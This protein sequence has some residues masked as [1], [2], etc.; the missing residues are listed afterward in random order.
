LSAIVCGKISAC[1]LRSSGTRTTPRDSASQVKAQY[2]AVDE[3]FTDLLR[4]S[5]VEELETVLAFFAKMN[6]ARSLTIT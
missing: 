3:Q 1:A 4:S 6:A 5:T 2:D